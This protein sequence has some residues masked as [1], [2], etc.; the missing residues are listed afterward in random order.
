M[1]VPTLV[2]GVG[3]G[4]IRV[5]QTLAEFVKD[6]GEVGDYRFIAI[7]SSKKDLQDRIKSG[8]NIIP[9]GIT[10]EGFDVEDM[11]SKCQ[12]LYEG[13]GGKGVGALRDRVYGRF[14]LDLNMSKVG[15]AVD[16]SLKDL[17]EK[18]KKERGEKKAQIMIWLVHTLGG[19]TGSGAFPSLV[20]NVHKLAKEILEDKDIKPYIFCV[21]VLPSA[22][23][24][25]DITHANFDKR[26]L[27]NSYSALRELELLANAKNITL[28]QF[29]PYGSNPEIEIMERPFNRYFLFGIDEDMVRRL[30]DE[31]AEAVDE[32]LTSSNKIIANMM[33]ALPNYPEGLENLWRDV[34]SPFIAFGES[35]LLV[36]IEEIKRVAKENDRLGKTV[37]EEI[38]KKL[39]GELDLVVNSS[40][41]ELNEGFLE[42]K[43]KAILNNHKLR[44]LSY[45]IGKSQNEFNKKATKAQTDFEDGVG[46]VWDELEREEWAKDKIETSE[47]LSIGD[48]YEK[49]VDMLE[50]RI[51]DIEK[52]ISSWISEKLHPILRR[53][54]NNEKGKHNKTLNEL[55]EKKDILDKLKLLK[56]HIDSNLCKSLRVEIGHE[57]DGVSEVTTHIRKLEVELEKQ[58]KK[59]SEEGGDRVVKLGIP[60]EKA[61]DLT[62]IEKG[63][64]VANV[65]SVPDF[66]KTFNIKDDAVEKLIKNRIE[67]ADDISIRVGIVAKEKEEKEAPSKEL[68]IL[69]HKDNEA[70][71]G[72]HEK[73]FTGWEKERII[74]ET[75]DRGKYVFVDFRLGLHL[76]DIKEYKYRNE[77][78]EDGTLAKTTGLKEDIGRIFAYPEWFMDDEN[79]K[80]VFKKIIQ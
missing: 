22:T 49:I 24:I 48:K 31:E 75:F 19:G 68:F 63:I 41:G 5:V 51:R 8:Y 79:V 69:C 16:A 54:L 28:T 80:G 66:I 62:M 64:N 46:D 47:G 13:A 20:V 78:Y 65:E 77:E 44:G 18:W 53:M 9:V 29:N 3:M 33:Y 25:K 61:N 39:K 73:A 21:G 34:K 11:I 2:V 30:K 12:Y 10:E 17:K 1:T 42:D 45:F 32:Y 74:T 43:C 52:T 6:K 55:S 35:E 36:P 57:E 27:A 72:K 23:N 7:D 37:E 4:G 14:L 56:S 60:E 50:D 15:E 71:L 26:Y 67:Q 59:L 70:T 58:Y 40:I 38:K 76:E